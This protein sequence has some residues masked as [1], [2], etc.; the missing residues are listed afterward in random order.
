MRAARSRAR[1]RTARTIRG[2]AAPRTRGCA[3]QQGLRAA[4]RRVGA[5]PCL[6]EASKRGQ[7]AT[8]A[9]F[10]AFAMAARSALRSSPPIRAARTFGAAS[11]ISRMGTLP[12]RRARVRAFTRDPS[13]AI[14][15]GRAA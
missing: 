11:R 13:A 4:E 9:S 2:A 15:Q 6:P 14:Y 3:S 10:A 8:A 7:L 5:V 12:D 1:L